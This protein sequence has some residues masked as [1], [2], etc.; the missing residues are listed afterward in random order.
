MNFKNE[1][2][3][4]KEQT[5]VESPMSD[6]TV[7][8]ES[9]IPKGDAT[10]N[11]TSLEAMQKQSQKLKKR[12]LLI[13]G[14]V[15]GGIV[16]LFA[17]VMLL[18]LWLGKGKDRLPEYDGTFYPPYEGDIFENPQYMSLDRQMYYC[19]DP[20]GDGLRQAI[21]E[22]NMT[23]FDT[24]IAFLYVYLQSIMMGDE[25]IY[26]AYFNE[27]YYQS[28]EPKTAFNPQMLYDIQIR[29]NQETAEG[30]DK[31]VTYALSY[32]IY[33]NDGSF[34]RDIGSDSSRTQLITLRVTAAGEISI[35]KLVT[36]LDTTVN[37]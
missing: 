35:E 14:C 13:L 5:I 11:L 33:R 1:N 26:N 34:R 6:T 8:L 21:T 12:I 30:A 16:V 23:E 18:E 36:R 4:Y 10:S 29:Y 20:N 31:L 37:S 7:S 27:N 32:K 19:E 17:L 24:N 3:V 15:V 28:S 9:N 2:E 22:E 25:D